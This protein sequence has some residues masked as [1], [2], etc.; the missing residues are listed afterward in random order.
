LLCYDFLVFEGKGRFLV[1][2][3]A[4]ADP[5]DHQ[6]V[7]PAPV[8]EGP[9]GSVGGKDRVPLSPAAPK[10]SER[11]PISEE[12]VDTARVGIRGRT[13]GDKGFIPCG[14]RKKREVI[15]EARV[16]DG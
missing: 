8:E 9:N 11:D 16:R 5:L 14:S 4:G 2:D 10:G 1:R 15:E 7:T 13:R 12:E 3:G 6:L